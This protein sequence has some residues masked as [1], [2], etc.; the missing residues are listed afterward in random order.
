M[1]LES[2]TNDFISSRDNILSLGFSAGDKKDKSFD[3]E[4]VRDRL[5]PSESFAKKSL[6]EE[7]PEINLTAFNKKSKASFIAISKEKG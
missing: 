7:S 6:M 5:K 2:A 3:S 1:G 4:N